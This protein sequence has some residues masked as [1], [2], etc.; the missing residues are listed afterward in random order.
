M[1]TT[2]NGVDFN[3]EISGRSGAPWV[4]FSHAL[5]TDLRIWDDQVGVLRDHF[6]ILR[7]DQR[8][9]GAS[10]APPGPYDF[11]ILVSDVIGL[12]DALD[13]V[14]SHWVGLSIGGMIGYGVALAHPERLHSLVACDSRPEAP[15]DYR[16]YFQY[17]IDTAQE[18][19]MEGL[20]EPTIERW[21]TPTTIAAE[22]A[23]LEHI[24]EM[25]RGTDPVGHAGCCEALKALAFE[26]RLAAIRT[27]TLIMGGADDKGAP[28][29]ALADA[30]ERIPGARHVVIAGAGHL[31]NIENPAQF[32]AA[33]QKFLESQV[34]A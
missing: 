27:P 19:G 32:N 10:S 7:Y 29:D 15:P 11:D 12:F 5:A 21:F 22:P 14:R 31:S 30:S 6:R 9:H 2:V 25:I 33:L 24:R 23:S 1:N 8:G 18:R 20:V 17:R 16:D 3:V 13:I 28:P 34:T 4:T 26:S